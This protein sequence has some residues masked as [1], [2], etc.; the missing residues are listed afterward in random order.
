MR[1]T[2]LHDV[3]RRLGAS[4]T[5]F[6]GWEMPLR[7][8][9]DVA[10]HHAVRQ[11]CGLF[12]LG[13][14]GQ[15]A[16]S[17]PDAAAFLDFALVGRLSAVAVGRAKYTMLCHTT[18]GVLDDLV[19]YRLAERS[20]LVVANAANAPMVLAML[21]EHSGGFAVTVTE[22]V[23]ALIAI[24]GPDAVKIVGEHPDL[25]YYAIKPERVAGRD[26]LLARTGYTGED[27]FEIYCAN[28]DAE[29]IW[30]WAAAA[31]A[32]PAGLAC[33][34]T[35]RLEAG[36][37]LYG[38]ELTVRTTPFDAGLGRVVARDKRDFV[39]GDALRAAEPVRELVGL[40][41]TGRRSPRAGYAVIDAETG[42]KVGEV[43]SGALSPTLGHPIALAYLRK[44][45]DR[46]RLAVDVRGT[47]IPA[48]IVK[49]PFY[50]R[51]KD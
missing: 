13:H 27:G 47:P 18:G 49:L 32:Q 41:T 9:S 5:G 31:G 15:I 12:D 39:G 16:V 28:E 1:R 30:A 43:T 10:E 19:V 22:H 6:A 14:M 42:A 37:P 17:G 45:L 38:H 51:K 34:D 25:R 23:G 2:A 26:V 46:A 3:H 36:M 50:R 29:A 8:G 7:Y 33:R 21:G 11:S 24:Q 44:N 20:F 40:V 48:E 4:M 35:L